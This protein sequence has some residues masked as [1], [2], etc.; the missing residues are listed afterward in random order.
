MLEG[1]AAEGAEQLVEH[2]RAKEEKLEVYERKLRIATRKVRTRTPT[3]ARAR[4]RAQ[5]RTRGANDNTHDT[6]HHH[7]PIF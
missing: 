1:A 3:R 7:R 6:H 5:A 4:A 2:E